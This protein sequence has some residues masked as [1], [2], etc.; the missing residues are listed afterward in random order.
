[1]REVNKIDNGRDVVK[2]KLRLKNYLELKNPK[3]F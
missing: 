2:K 3:N 1:M